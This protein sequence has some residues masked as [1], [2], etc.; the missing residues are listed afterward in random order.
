MG[1]NK[2]YSVDHRDVGHSDIIHRV[3]DRVGDI[4]GHL[5]V[6]NRK[7]LGLSDDEGGCVRHLNLNVDCF[8]D[9]RRRDKELDFHCLRAWRGS[10]D[11][12]HLRTPEKGLEVGSGDRGGGRGGCLSGGERTT[13]APGWHEVLEI[14]ERECRVST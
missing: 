8:L 1:E 6:D 9:G 5:D 12:G 13:K 11:Q 7:F 14:C 3:V 10:R 2:S 4:V